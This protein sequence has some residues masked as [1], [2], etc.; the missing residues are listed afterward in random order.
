MGGVM[1]LFLF[2]Y[3]LILFSVYFFRFFYILFKLTNVGLFAW[4]LN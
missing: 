1:C 2:D 3:V 4:I